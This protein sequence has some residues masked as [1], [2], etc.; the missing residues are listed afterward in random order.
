MIE[1]IEVRT[2]QGTLLNLPMDDISSGF[3][4]EEVQGLDPV[5]ATLVSS[6]FANFDGQVYH[7]SRR[8]SRNI[9]LKLA[10]EPDYATETVRELRSRLY[11]FFMPKSKVDLR[12][13][14]ED[15]LEAD[16][17]GRVET[18][19][20]DLFT[21]EPEATISLM[22]FDPDFYDRNVETFN[23]NTTDTSVNSNIDYVG[24]V[25]TGVVFTLNVNRTI[26][27]FTLYSEPPDGSLRQMD[28]AAA[29]QAGDVLEISTVPGSKYASLTRAGST[30]SILYGISPQASWFELQPGSND[31]RVYATG[32]AI[33]YTIEYTTKYGGL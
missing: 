13:K 11:D 29:L 10:L 32:L 18:L 17:S 23:G 12:F 28:F 30:T 24:T 3:A 8:D 22:C 4:V 7:S 14:M 5:R 27:E 6:S 1:Q 2:Q 15:G 9:I 21:D 31:F 26:S 19:E 25:E 33:P 16:I 20:T